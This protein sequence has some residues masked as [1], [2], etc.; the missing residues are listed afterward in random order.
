MLTMSRLLTHVLSFLASLVIRLRSFSGHRTPQKMERVGGANLHL[1]RHLLCGLL[2]TTST[3]PRCHLGIENLRFLHSLAVRETPLPPPPFFFPGDNSL[4]AS[5]IPGGSQRGVFS[6]SRER[7]KPCANFRVEA[8]L[9]AA[10]RSVCQHVFQ[11]LA[12]AVLGIWTQ[13][14]FLGVERCEAAGFG[15]L[16]PKKKKKH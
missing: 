1:G 15:G 11:P 4:P 3:L 12:G 2:I 10:L 7:I 13:G 8:R 6:P 9:G 14:V 16:L 5:C